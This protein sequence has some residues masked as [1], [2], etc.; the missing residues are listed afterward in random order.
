MRTFWEHCC[1]GNE[2]K[3]PKFGWGFRGLIPRHVHL[4]IVFRVLFMLKFRV[5]HVEQRFRGWM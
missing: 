5:K 1:C 4:G 3:G 2:S